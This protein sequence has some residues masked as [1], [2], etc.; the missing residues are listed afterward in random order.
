MPPRYYF[1]I[2]RPRRSM[3]PKPEPRMSKEYYSFT[4]THCHEVVFVNALDLRAVFGR[5]LQC[6]CCK[7]LTRV[8][9][10]TQSFHD[11]CKTCEKLVSCIAN[12]V[13][14]VGTGTTI[15]KKIYPLSEIQSH[16][17]LAV[18]ITDCIC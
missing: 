1:R 14:R 9:K 10:R 3:R 16:V 6:P 13:I 7:C 2:R 15:K 12:P 5:L 4:C 11:K 18:H 17:M 8:Y